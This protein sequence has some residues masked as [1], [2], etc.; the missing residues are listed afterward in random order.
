M[1]I[2]KNKTLLKIYLNEQKFVKG[3]PLYEYIVF[4]AK[5]LDL[6]GATVTKGVMSYGKKGNLHTSSILNLSEDLP[7]IIEII[8][9]K[10]KINNLLEHL[11]DILNETLVIIQD[12]Q[13]VR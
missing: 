9:F 3:T 4:K 8:D 11:K 10:E 2:Y 1:K 12:L 13:E 5:E 6:L 7:I